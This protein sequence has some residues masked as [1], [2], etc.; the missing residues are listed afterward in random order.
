MDEKKKI[1]ILCTGNS[2]RSQMGEGLLL[3]MAGDGWQVESA[4]TK[5]AGLNPLAVEA[6]KEFGIDISAQRS[7]S[8]AEFGDKKFDFVI[9][10]CDSAAESC[11]IFPN[12]PRRI[13]WSLPDPAAVQGTHQEK[14]VA[15][16]AVRDR[17]RQHLQEWLTQISL[18]SQS[19]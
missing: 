8:V 19:N 10:V 2:A 15:F 12:A 17:L 4:G 14:L 11:P 6:M 9:T 3:H 1:L 16:R 13:H 18:S 5:P 7:K